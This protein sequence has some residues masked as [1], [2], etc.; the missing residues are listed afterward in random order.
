MDTEAWRAAIHGVAK[1]RTWLSNWT[2]L[3]DVQK[4]KKSTLYKIALFKNQKEMYLSLQVFNRVGL[5]ITFSKLVF[6]RFFFFSTFNV[7]NKEC[8]WLL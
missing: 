2:E 8:A 7:F 4:K 1:S 6:V 5:Y 3:K